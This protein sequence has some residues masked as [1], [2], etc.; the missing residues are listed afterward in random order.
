MC[1]KRAGELILKTLLFILLNNKT[2]VPQVIK[3]ER[4][5]NLI[6]QKQRPELG[7]PEVLLMPDRSTFRYVKIDSVFG[8]FF[9][10]MTHRLNLTFKNNLTIF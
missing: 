3:K 2:Y 4:T 5:L 10:Q 1:S 6:H 9:N 7:M 8:F